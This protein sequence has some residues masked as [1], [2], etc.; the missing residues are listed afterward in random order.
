MSGLDECYCS[1]NGT[2]WNHKHIPIHGDFLVRDGRIYPITEVD[3]RDHTD[4]FYEFSVYVQVDDEGDA[5]T[6]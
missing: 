4:E 2:K 3:S 1:C 6:L 5:V